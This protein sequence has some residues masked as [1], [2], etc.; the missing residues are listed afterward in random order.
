[1][2]FG[3]IKWVFR[4]VFLK[5]N[6]FLLKLNKILTKLVFHVP[7]LNTPECYTHKPTRISLT[8]TVHVQLVCSVCY[9]SCMVV[10]INALLA[11][12]RITEADCFQILLLGILAWIPLFSDIDAVAATFY[13]LANTYFL[14][15]RIALLIVLRVLVHLIYLV[16]FN[17][18]L[19]FNFLFFNIEQQ[20]IY[21]SL[22]KYS[23]LVFDVVLH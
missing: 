9:L 6:T 3:N 23:L 20:I 13:V 14:T 18:F 22:D 16:I 8:Q 2:V 1:M 5:A 11:E 7:H 12:W 19:V 4:F 17:N 10:N 21:F 15:F